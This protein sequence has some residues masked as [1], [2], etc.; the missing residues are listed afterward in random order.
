MH[1]P[2]II[3]KEKLKEEE[4]FEHAKLFDDLLK[5]SHKGNLLRYKNVALLFSGEKNILCSKMSF[6][7]LLNNNL[8]YYLGLHF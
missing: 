5:E 7:L 8:N 3:F 2:P 1:N 4:N 6:Y